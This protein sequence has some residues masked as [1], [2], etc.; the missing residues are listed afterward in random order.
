MGN[1]RKRL[2]L[3]GSAPDENKA[4]FNTLIE[5]GV[6]ELIQANDDTTINKILCDVLGKDYTYENL[7]SSRSDE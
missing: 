6:L 5:M 2:L 7:V 1:I 3:S 4:I